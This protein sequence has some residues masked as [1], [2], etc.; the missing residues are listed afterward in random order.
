MFAD[1]V[2]NRMFETGPE[3]L[4]D[5]LGTVAEGFVIGNVM[6]LGAYLTTGALD[7]T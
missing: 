2:A 1:I 7:T 4:R 3:L 5:V 6:L